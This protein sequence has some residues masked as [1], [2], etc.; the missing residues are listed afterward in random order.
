MR[1][2]GVHITNH[3]SDSS[4]IRYTPTVQV[5][6]LCSCR[7]PGHLKQCSCRSSCH[8][9]G[10]FPTVRQTLSLSSPVVSIRILP[11]YTIRIL[12]YFPYPDPL[13]HTLS[14]S[15]PVVPIRILSFMHGMDHLKLFLY[16]W[17]SSSAD[18]I[19]ILP[20]CPYPDR[21]SSSHMTMTG[22]SSIVIQILSSCSYP[23]PFPQTLFSLVVPDWSILS[24]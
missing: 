17:G 21:A 7:Y 15:S 1:G 5:R 8:L 18:N 22:G 4:V 13:W 12:S 14:G 20:I 23:D 24:G 16:A 9:S 2:K 6:S 11:N 19:W 3:P 10:S